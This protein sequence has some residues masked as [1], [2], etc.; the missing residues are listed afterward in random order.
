MRKHLLVFFLII[1]KFSSEFLSYDYTTIDLIKVRLV[2]LT[3]CI[4]ELLSFRKFPQILIQT[5]VVA[6]SR[7]AYNIPV[8]KILFHFFPSDLFLFSV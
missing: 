6:G 3:L 5:Q 7:R 2:C 8:R 4:N 1:G